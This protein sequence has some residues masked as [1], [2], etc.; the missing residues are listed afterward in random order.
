VAAPGLK[1]PCLPRA[2]AA[3]TPLGQPIGRKALYIQIAREDLRRMNFLKP[4]QC[5]HT[6]HNQLPVLC[7]RTRVTSY[8]FLSFTS[9]TITLTLE[10][11]NATAIQSLGADNLHKHPKNSYAPRLHP[12][13]STPPKLDRQNEQAWTLL[14][15]ST[16]S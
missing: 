4:T 9:T 13:G 12:L 16:Y 7:L 1:Y 3:V 15:T 2:H 14:T 6:R 10:M 11:T 5:L 8:I